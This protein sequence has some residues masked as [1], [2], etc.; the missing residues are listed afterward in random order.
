MSEPDDIFRSGVLRSGVYRRPA[1]TWPALVTAALSA[2]AVLVMVLWPA[3][4]PPLPTYTL[5]IVTGGGP[6]P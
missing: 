2:A 6:P 3:T 5:E 1:P 4:E